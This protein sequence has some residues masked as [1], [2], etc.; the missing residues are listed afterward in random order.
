MKICAWVD[1]DRG[2]SWCRANHVFLG[3]DSRFS[4]MNDFS[5]VST[6]RGL[7][8]MPKTW[9]FLE[10]LLVWVVS[11]LRFL[12]NEMCGALEWYHDSLAHSVVWVAT[13]SVAV[14]A[15]A[16]VHQQHQLHGA[17]EQS[18]PS[19]VDSSKSLACMGSLAFSLSS[20]WNSMPWF[21]L[22]SSSQSMGSI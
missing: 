14:N 2:V 7:K 12:G 4:F 19:A 3:I 9:F 22:L 5:L 10:Q 11:S 8:I 1:Y 16:S 13:W 6:G 18:S 15:Q 21:V 20:A 17:T